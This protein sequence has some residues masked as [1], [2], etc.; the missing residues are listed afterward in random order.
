MIS[1]GDIAV[2]RPIG[3][4]N[5]NAVQ[6]MI[7]EEMINLAYEPIS[8]PI[9]CNSWKK[10]PSYLEQNGSRIEIFPSPFSKCFSGKGLIIPCGRVDELKN[11]LIRGNILFIHGEIT[12]EPLMP[13]DF[14]FYFPEEHKNI[15]ET[16]EKAKPSCVIALTGKS[17]LCGLDPFPFF[18]DGPQE[19]PSAY[20]SERLIGKIITGKEAIIEIS[21][22]VERKIAEQ[23]VFKKEGHPKGKIIICAHMD[24]KYG[25]PGALD[26][27][28]GVYTLTK[29]AHL[30]SNEKDLPE[31]EIVPFNGEEYHGVSG[32]LKYLEYSGDSTIRC[33]INIDSPGYLG[34]KNALSFYN[35]DEEEISR[36][37]TGKDDL[38]RGPEWY[39]GDHAMFVFRGCPCIVATSSNLFEEAI[40]VTH[41]DKDDLSMVD[42]SLLNS[43][44]NSLKEIIIDLDINKV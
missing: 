25:T 20:V 27:A 39:A 30:L 8:L 4:D 6:E 13:K 5:N 38:S 32:Q 40:K 2:E 12:K 23:M 3:S 10:G 24:T 41:T 9:E 34:S 21:S 37:M 36:A 33:V 35:L 17:S 7:K 29:L 44:A 14:P 19:I 31:I 43:L 11:P 42:V 16:I 28:A 26:N 22:S 15:Y 18:E 1:L